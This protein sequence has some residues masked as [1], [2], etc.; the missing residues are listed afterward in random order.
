M[1]WMSIDAEATRICMP[2]PLVHAD[3]RSLEVAAPGELLRRAVQVDAAAGTHHV[4]A[5]RDLD[6]AGGVLLDEQHRDAVL[7]QS[8]EDFEH[9]VDHQRC[10]PEGR[11]VE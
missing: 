5:V 8:V 7:A 10:E 4:G 9:A 6:R 1:Y 2:S 11:L 3:V